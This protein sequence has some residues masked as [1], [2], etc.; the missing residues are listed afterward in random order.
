MAETY[1]RPVLVSQINRPG[2][3]AGWFSSRSVNRYDDVWNT[4]L[5]FDLLRKSDAFQLDLTSGVPQQTLHSGK[6]Y[7]AFVMRI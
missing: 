4:E 1:G 5:V 7:I 3:L 6:H 2:G